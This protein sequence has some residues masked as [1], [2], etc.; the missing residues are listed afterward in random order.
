M[1]SK[2]TILLIILTV[3]VLHFVYTN[4]N[5]QFVSSRLVIGVVTEKN[6]TE[7]IKFT[8]DIL[9]VDDSGKLSKKET[10][11]VENK[12]VWNLIEVDESYMFVYKINKKNQTEF[13]LDQIEIDKT[14]KENFKYK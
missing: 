1:K 10:I 5:T 8:V 2:K 13:Y 11:F 3:I 14:I 7:D 12:N 6:K 9:R 4:N